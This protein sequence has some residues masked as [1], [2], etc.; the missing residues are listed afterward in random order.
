MDVIVDR[1]HESRQSIRDSIGDARLSILSLGTIFIL[2]ATA[3]LSFLWEGAAMAVDRRD[4]GPAWQSIIN[5]SWATITVTISA[6]IIRTAISLQAGVVMSMVAS[7]L[8][9]RHS[10]QFRDAAFLSIVRA[11]SVQP[12]TMLLTGGRGVLKSSGFLCFPVV[13]F[14]GLVALTATFTSTILLSDFA[15]IDIVGPVATTLV[16]YT[17]Q[18]AVAQ[19]DL[20]KSPPVPYA[21]FAEYTNLTRATGAHIDDTGLTLRALVPLQNSSDR[22]TLRLYQGPATVFDHRVI[23]V[24]PQLTI[25]NISQIGAN[26]QGAFSSE[27]LAVSGSASFDTDL[28][29]PLRAASPAT[30]IPFA[31]AFPEFNR[32]PGLKWNMSICTVMPSLNLN[33]TPPLGITPFLPLVT[34]D[35]LRGYRPPI[36]FVLNL[37]SPTRPSGYGWSDVIGLAAL[38]NGTFV[39][40]QTAVVTTS[41]GPW[42][43]AKILDVPA[44]QDGEFALSACITSTAGLSYNVSITSPSDGPEPSLGW[45]GAILT[46]KQTS[47]P[48]YAYDTTAVRHQLGVAG[49]SSL[50]PS[51]RGIMDLDFT[52]IDGAA[53][54]PNTTSVDLSL[55]NLFPSFGFSGI[56]LEE[57]PRLDRGTATNPTAILAYSRGADLGHPGHVTLF[58]DT[59]YETNSPAR[60][61]QAWITTLTRQN[62]Y[63]AQSRFTAGSD[64]TL[65]R[66]VTVLAPSRRSGL[67]GVAA[68]LAVHLAIVIAVTIWYVKETRHSKLGNSWMAVAQVVSAATEPVLWRAD[69]ARDAEVERILREET[70]AGDGPHGGYGIVKLRKSGR[71]EMIAL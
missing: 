64:A 68:V 66:S 5:R 2:A 47:I 71:R 62:F 63:D 20:W 39:V 29:A 61:L 60:A 32:A 65:T 48:Q 37:T 31:C 4:P 14:T 22:E 38:T 3:V 30:Q 67:A 41:D 19:L 50:P 35:F 59:L 51:D 40:P 34:S 57:P 53:P 17:N 11:V 8:L 7:V 23:C 44:L 27:Y 56:P 36:F 45:T 24:A 49:P 18:S 58:H 55:R 33:Y 6:A 70:G 25:S 52:T 12:I 1:S 54:Y 10:V 9:E 43:R 15:N 16:A 46:E 26:V 69:A 28:P 13:L 21:R 42:T